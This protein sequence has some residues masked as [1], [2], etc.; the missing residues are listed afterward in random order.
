MKTLQPKL[1]IAK[2][3]VSSFENSKQMYFRS[4]W[5]CTEIG[6]A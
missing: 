3:V 5:V 1:I 6:S 2:K 4:T